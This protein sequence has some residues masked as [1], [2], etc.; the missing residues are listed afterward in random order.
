MKKIGLM[1]WYKYPNYGTVLQSSA[2]FY[3]IK[4]MGYNPEL[5]NYTPRK[6]YLDNTKINPVKFIFNKIFIK[7]LN[8]KGNPVNKKLFKDFQEDITSESNEVKTY[9]DLSTLT[10]TYDAVVCG[11]DQIWSPLCFDD[12]YY[13]PFVQTEKKIA[14]APSLGVQKISNTNIENKISD[15]V[16]EFKF[17]SVRENDGADIIRKISGKNPEVVLD[18]T[19]LLKANEWK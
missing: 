13:L 5:I 19:L 8:N 3:I 4:K 14:Y 11:S 6:K 17:L 7:V 9:S 12:Y 18:P 1:T 16:E 10:K 2:L 15:L